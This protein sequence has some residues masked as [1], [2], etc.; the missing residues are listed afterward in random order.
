MNPT[1]SNLHTHADFCDGRQ[2]LEEMIEAA[3]ALEYL[4]LGFSS[5]STL[6]FDNVYAMTP[7]SELAYL[8]AMD[9]MKEKYREDIELL[10]GL[11]WDLDTAAGFV[12]FDRYDYLIG[13]VHQLHAKGRV[14][15]VDA[16]RE[17]LEIC[18]NEGYDGDALAMARA[19]Y[20][21]VVTCVLRP[22]VDIVGH[23][24]LLRKYNRSTDFFNENSPA[25]QNIALEAL[26][27]VLAKRD[28]LVFEVNFGGM[29]RAGLPTP[30]PDAFLMHE[31]RT[32]GARI[33][34]QADAH[35]AE[36][37]KDGW[38]EAVRYVKE[39]GFNHVYRLRQDT[40][41]EKVR[42]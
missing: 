9:A 25:Y 17:D 8:D 35:S 36:G 38:D 31:L 15:A 32:R 27:S 7:R 39:A 41:W 4:S 11:E 33:T 42:L 3:I 20:E 2:P 19:Y 5:H 10:T 16:S 23:F 18:I 24:D 34:L 28:D 14:F 12:P 21:A 1:Q 13:S 29:L 37:L 22:R 30:Y 40:I 6:P 26:R